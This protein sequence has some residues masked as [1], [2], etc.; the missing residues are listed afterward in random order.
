MHQALTEARAEAEAAAEQRIAAALALKRVEL[1]K[2]AR[3]WLCMCENRDVCCTAIACFELLHC[4]CTRLRVEPRH[5]IFAWQR[6][7]W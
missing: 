5:T 1:D 4:V 6:R 2:Q 3:S 7:Q